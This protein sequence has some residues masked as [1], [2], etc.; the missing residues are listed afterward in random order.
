[1]LYETTVISTSPVARVT[2]CASPPYE[3]AMVVGS[4]LTY[5]VHVQLIIAQ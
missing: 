2:T 5:V 4:P 3:H 1:M